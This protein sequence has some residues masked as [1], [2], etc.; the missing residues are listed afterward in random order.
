[1]TYAEQLRDLPTIDKLRR[2]VTQ[3]STNQSN[4]FSPVWQ[5]GLR[6]LASSI[7][8]AHTH[9]NSASVDFL[10]I[11]CPS[12]L[13]Q[14]NIMASST[15]NAGSPDTN[16][17]AT[18]ELRSSA[19]SESVGVPEFYA[20]SGPALQ[21]PFPAPSHL[22]G[23]AARLVKAP[24]FAKAWRLPPCLVL[25]RFDHYDPIIRRS[26]KPRVCIQATV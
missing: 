4:A 26:T 13:V 14:S 8:G 18:Q 23:A 6:R 5:L 10:S 7:C 16:A 15:L 3:C 12:Q 17:N 24:S 20:R 19:A 21:I 1:M 9:H 25:T 22:R 11:F 2:Y